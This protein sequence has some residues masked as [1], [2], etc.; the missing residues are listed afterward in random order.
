MKKNAM[1][2]KAKLLMIILSVALI[3]PL[4]IAVQVAYQMALGNAS[5]E[6][7]FFAI[8]IISAHLE[9]AVESG[10]YSVFRTL[11]RKAELAIVAED[12][13]VLYATSGAASEAAPGRF[14]IPGADRDIHAFAFGTA[15]TRGTAW[16]SLPP[17]MANAGTNPVYI[18]PITLF[19]LLA[20]VVAISMLIARSLGASIRKLEDATRKI[21]A[22]DLDFPSSELASGDLASLG[23][24]LDRMR[25]QLK[26]DRERR[27]R[28][29]MGVS[30]DL[31]T[32]LAVI[33]GYLDALDD[34]LADT[35][36]KRARYMAIL[37]SKADLLGERIGHL[38]ELAKTTTSEWRHTLA[39][40]D[41]GSFLEETLSPLAEYCAIRGFVL[42]WNLALAEPCILPFDRDMI[43]RVLENLVG[44]AVSYGDSTVPI[45]A[46]ARIEG[47]AILLRVENGG[48]G[49]PDEDLRKVFEP[50]FRG[51][52]SRKDGGFGLGLASVKS[53]VETHGW[54][55]EAESEPG[56][57]TAFIIRIPLRPR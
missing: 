49:I 28:F 14:I 31:K 27:D 30:H 47:R 11:P 34:G 16:L 20:V 52:R 37:R 43:A 38:I 1:D 40:S 33:Q 24:S 44:N 4:T 19:F 7:L 51:S 26:E 29:I 42:E 25:A 55:I 9:N 21:A 8:R 18:L 3:P 32:P 17:T 10:D 13:T 41:F 54:S 57:R 39:E 22:G 2:M 6:S 56:S 5:P 15:G 12:G 53:I 23:L 46:D 45:L 48:P 36:E 50:F 35:E